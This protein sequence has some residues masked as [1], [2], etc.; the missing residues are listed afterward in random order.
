MKKKI[1]IGGRIVGKFEDIKRIANELGF[2]E[3]KIKGKM[4]EMRKI[5][6]EDIAGEEMVGYS[7]VVCSEYLEF[8][9]TLEDEK[10]LKRIIEMTHLFLALCIALKGVF[11]I[12]CWK[13]IEEADE[14]LKKLYKVIDSEK[15]GI[16]EENEILKRKLFE[17][18]K[19]YNDLL[20]DNERNA[21]ILLEC[22]KKRDE[23]LS[24][25]NKLERLSLLEI[26][27][28]VFEYLKQNGGEIDIAEFAQLHHLPVRKIEYA[29][30]ELIKEGYIKRYR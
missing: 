30:N 12:E 23:Y 9:Y 21:R 3:V 6:M 28:L 14:V 15:V 4:V 29:L 20:K 24:K 1:H 7:V 27:G 25:L 26:K 17:L 8:I 16:V 10:D 11:E 2:D 18:E 22:E 5:E 13:A 19:K